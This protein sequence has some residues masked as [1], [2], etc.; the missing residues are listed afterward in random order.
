MQA[1]SPK[2]DPRVIRTRQ[3]IREAFLELIQEYDLEKI[4]VNRLA[5]RATI[6]RVTFYLHYRDIPDMLNQ[7]ADNMTTHIR[8]L[9]EDVADHSCS[10]KDEWPELVKLIQHFADHSASYKILLASKR[11]PLF[12]E[13][14]SVLMMD[15]IKSKMSSHNAA[16]K[17]ITPE[18]PNDI[19]AWYGASAFLGTIVIWLRNDMPYT[20]AFLAKQLLLM[21]PFR[22]NVD[23]S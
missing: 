5:E 1:K 13:R 9:L 20:P 18:I 8:N 22:S 2:M 11:L 3:L 21:A 15:Y 16:S 6:N 4:T 12:T 10:A 14:L 19:T 23:S 17:A 7:M